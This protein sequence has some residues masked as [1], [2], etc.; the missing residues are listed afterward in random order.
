MILHCTA[1]RAEK[2]ENLAMFKN[3]YRLGVSLM[4]LLAF[5]L[6]LPSALAQNGMFV[7][8]EGSGSGWQAGPAAMYHGLDEDLIML[9][10]N[11]NRVNSQ[12]YFAAASVLSTSGT[13][14][15]TLNTAFADGGVVVTN[16]NASS[17]VGEGPHACAVQ[18]DGKLLSGGYSTQNKG[19]QVFALL[20]YDTD[21]TLDKTFNKSGIVKTGFS[22]GIGFPSICA[23]ALQSDGKIVVAGWAYSYV[24][25]VDTIIVARYTT[26]GQLD[27]TFG[28]GG[29]NAITQS[30]SSA[31]LRPTAVV[32]QSDGSIVVGA[33]V[34]NPNNVSHQSMA[35]TRYTSSGKL[36]GSFGNGGILEFSVPGCITSVVND[37]VVDADNT[38][39][40]AGECYDGS[41]DYLTLVRSASDGS[42]LDTTFGGGNGYITESFGTTASSVALEGEQIVISGVATNDNL[43][44]AR[45]DSDGTPDTTFG[46][47]VVNGV[48][49]GYSDDFAISP[50][51]V[52]IQ[53]D[54]R[55]VVVGGLPANV[56][57]A[58][59]IVRYNIDGTVDKSF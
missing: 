40:V 23:I 8:P 39:I 34:H 22:S 27:S 54:G 31:W 52:L 11:T 44:V 45:F 47:V 6:G 38:I 9:V 12:S 25:A 43:L 2:K 3:W 37:I 28:S 41:R 15:C 33:N 53:L 18:P 42:A 24:P 51:Q 1:D 20:R 5:G 58:G 49:Q 56:T 55:I 48:P 26:S 50:G 36:D 19:Q 21:G 30:N 29:I 7:I 16:V 13:P 46:S 14:G 59:T 4:T 57:G 32:L 35:L 17:W 10:G